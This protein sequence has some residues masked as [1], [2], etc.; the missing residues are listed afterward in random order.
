[1]KILPCFHVVVYLIA[2]VVAMLMIH[3]PR[4]YAYGLASFSHR[5][6]IV[7]AAAMSLAVLNVYTRLILYE[8]RSTAA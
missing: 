3:Q 4:K 1:V 7:P 8:C 6:R 5:V 2:H